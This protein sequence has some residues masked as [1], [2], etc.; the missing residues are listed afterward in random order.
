MSTINICSCK[1]QKC[2]SCKFQWTFHMGFQMDK[3]TFFAI[4]CVWD[5]HL[6][7][8]VYDEVHG[9]HMKLLRGVSSL[10]CAIMCMHSPCI[11]LL[12]LWW[13][14]RAPLWR[15]HTNDHNLWENR[16]PTNDH[17]RV[18]LETVHFDAWATH[19]SSSSNKA[20]TSYLIS[21]SKKT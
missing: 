5:D 10:P 19:V 4:T 8:V 1:V 21:S 6:I 16:M 15:W 17:G 14:P 18:W 9:V 12:L 2:C 3:N 7:W 11:W 20:W 13:N